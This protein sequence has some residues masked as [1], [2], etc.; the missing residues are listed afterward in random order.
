M[1]DFKPSVEL[2]ARLPQDILLGIENHRLVDKATDTFQAVKDLKPLFSKERRRFSGVITDIVFDYFL[3][4]HWQRFAAIEQ[5]QL[6]N[7]AYQ[8]LLECVDWMPARMEYVVTNMV[9][10]D[11]LNSYSTLDGIGTTL[12]H[13]SQRIRFKNTLAGSISEVEKNYEAIERV[14]LI[15]F[16]HLDATVKLARI[17]APNRNSTP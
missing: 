5:Q 10:H 14:F 8:G 11:W 1:G 15:L 17:E 7:D 4:K 6:I 16:E 9:E 2:K 3:I 13:V 12:D